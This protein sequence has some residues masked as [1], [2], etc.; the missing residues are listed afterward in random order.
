MSWCFWK[1]SGG[2]TKSQ[3]LFKQTLLSSIL[4]HCVARQTIGYTA[5]LCLVTW[6]CR[7]T[8]RV[9]T[10]LV[11][12]ISM[13]EMYSIFIFLASGV[14][15]VCHTTTGRCRMAG[16]TQDDRKVLLREA[17]QELHTKDKFTTKKTCIRNE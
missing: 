17:K 2:C 6:K 12:L 7:T 13:H 8:R 1:T 3:I 14:T 11:G 5:I 15:R 16:K 9:Q 10:M 4:T